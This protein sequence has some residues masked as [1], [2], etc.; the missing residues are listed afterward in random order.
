MLAVLGF[1][2]T[3]IIIVGIHEL[4]HYT[5]AR[6]CGVRVLAFSIGFGKPLWR[7]IDKH[8]TQWQLA[9]IPLGGYVSMLAT[10]AEAA[11]VDEPPERA[12]EGIPRYK[13]A[14]VIF[15]GPLANF[16]LTFVLFFCV[17]IIGEES[18]RAQVGRVLPDSAAEHAGMVAGD[19]IIAVDERPA[20]LW[21]TVVENLVFAIGDHDAKLTLQ[22]ASGV[23]REVTLPTGPA[24]GPQLMDDVQ[25]LEALGI[26]PDTSYISLELAAVIDN[27]PAAAAGLQIG[28]V[29][30]AARGEILEDWDQLVAMIDQSAEQELALVVARDGEIVELTATPVLWP[31]APEDGGYLGVVPVV[32]PEKF[33][34]MLG[35]QSAGFVDAFG[36]AAERT[37]RAALTVLRF[38]GLMLSQDM[39]TDNLSGPVAIAQQ[40]AS[41]VELGFV[42]FF[43]FIAQLSLSLGL[44]NLLPIPLLDGAYLLRYAIEGILRRPL[45][46]KIL[47][48]AGI[49][50]GVIL[51]A[52]MIFAFINDFT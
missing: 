29:M 1:L 49:A 41:A 9:L 25:I 8:G 12:L 24:T 7:H 34:A 26:I 3:C 46:P 28:D 40:S 2:I 52:L 31:D 35:R 37:G 4:G 20:F 18:L 38:I 43:L 51:L 6:M 5:A 16:V 19:Q 17:A 13:R 39:S 30:V 23:T 50:G 44:L 47:R 33:D 27:S 45:P 21:H 11:K 32:L 14:W 36:Q 22:A 42:V 48:I 15:A 10:P